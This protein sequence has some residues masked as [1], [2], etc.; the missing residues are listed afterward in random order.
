MS[1]FHSKP[2]EEVIRTF[3]SDPE[4][5]LSEQ[6]VL[7]AREQYGENKLMEKEGKTLLH[8]IIEQISDVMII[9][10]IFRQHVVFKRIISVFPH[11]YEFYTIFAI[12]VLE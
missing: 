3:G 4:S 10:L 8:Q 7:E 6:A 1:D 12:E 5:G 2:I 9:I 11:P